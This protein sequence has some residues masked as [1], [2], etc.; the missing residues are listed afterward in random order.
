MWKLQIKTILLVFSIKYFH[1]F[2]GRGLIFTTQFRIWIALIKFEF[3]PF[4]SDD[5]FYKLSRLPNSDKS[6]FIIPPHLLLS[7]SSILPYLFF[8]LRIFRLITSTVSTETRSVFLPVLNFF[9][10]LIIAPLFTRQ[11]PSTSNGFLSR[12]FNLNWKVPLSFTRSINSSVSFEKAHSPIRSAPIFPSDGLWLQL[13]TTTMRY[14]IHTGKYFILR[15]L[16]FIKFQI[17]W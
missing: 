14:T 12:I 11:V 2:A 5:F 16:P 10:F 6:N 3:S 7:N 1:G 9:H 15:P 8:T 13:V 17:P 4:K